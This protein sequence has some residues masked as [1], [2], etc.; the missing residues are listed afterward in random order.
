MSTQYDKYVFLYYLGNF[1]RNHYIRYEIVVTEEYVLSRSSMCYGLLV[2]IPMSFKAETIF[3]Y[4]V[5][6]KAQC[7]FRPKFRM[8]H[9]VSRYVESCML[10]MQA[11]F[12]HR[13]RQYLY[14]FPVHDI[15]LRAKPSALLEKTKKGIETI[16]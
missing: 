15:R 1:Q 14:P 4:K 12:K 9:L 16:F 10:K 7:C 5:N 6:V 8:L 3:K 11:E 13:F 2:C